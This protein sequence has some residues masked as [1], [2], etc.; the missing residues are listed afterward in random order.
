MNDPVD[1]EQV[2]REVQAEVLEQF[3]V[4]GIDVNSVESMSRARDDLG[5]VNRQRNRCDKAS[6]A[7]VLLLLGGVATTLGGWVVTGFE[8]FVKAL[9][10][11]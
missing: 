10:S 3:R 2:R 7:L 4:L 9:G 8:A 6:G 11:K 1:L 5:W